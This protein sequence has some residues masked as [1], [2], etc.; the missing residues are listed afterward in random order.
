[1]KIN[2]VNLFH[3]GARDKYVLA[4]YF[5]KIEKLDSFITDYWIKPN[6]LIFIFLGNKVKRRFNKEL[7]NVISYN[8]FKIFW[9]VLKSGLIKSSVFERWIA[10]DKKFCAYVNSKLRYLN[11]K[12]GDTIFWG[13][14]NASLEVFEML[15]KTESK[16]IK[17]LNQIDPGIEYYDIYLNL[18]KENQDVE[19]RP[20]TI[21]KVFEKRIRAEW[22]IADFIIVNSLYSKNCLIRHGV[23]EKKIGVLEL[24]FDSEDSVISR[25]VN[26]DNPLRVG[27]VGNINIIKGFDLFLSAAIA[28][29]G[30]MVFLAAGNSSL[31]P[32]YANRAEKFINFVGHLDK[33]QMKS[34]YQNIDILCFPTYSDGFGLVQLE[35]MSMGIPVLATKYCGN[36]VVDGHNGF[37]IK[38]DP[39]DI[40]SK[41]QQLDNRLLL[42]E[43]S[44]NAIETSQKFS[45]NNFDG[46]IKGLL[47]EF[48]LEL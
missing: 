38:N 12:G 7:E 16:G 34:L 48:K 40:I 35:A 37:I 46:K 26:A 8:S 18:W 39:D 11:L 13:Y 9:G 24:P 36:V 21:T 32:I 19:Q 30:S 45:V 27:F 10:H 25:K 17:V 14:T 4:R 23:V 2:K 15:M 31:K 20:E 43:L 5:N 47:A 29:N 1:M 22:E 41:L 6:S 33:P 42:Q 28:L 44:D 3:V